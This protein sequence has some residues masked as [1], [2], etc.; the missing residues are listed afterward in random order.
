MVEHRQVFLGKGLLRSPPR[1]AISHGN[2]RSG[3][4]AH[5]PQAAN[6]AAGVSSEVYDEFLAIQA[7]NCSVDVARNI[8]A[9]RAGEHAYLQPTDASFFD[10]GDRLQLDKGTLFRFGFRHSEGQSHVGA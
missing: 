8:D 1:D 10:E 9:D 7:L 6:S 5:K 3:E 4:I 2:S